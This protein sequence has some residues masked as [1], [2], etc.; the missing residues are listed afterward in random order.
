VRLRIEEIDRHWPM[1]RACAT[2]ASGIQATA[3][4]RA[5]GSKKAPLL[6]PIRTALERYIS[7]EEVAGRTP[8]MDRACEQILEQIP[9]AG[10][11]WVREIYRTMVQQE[12]GRPRK[13][14]RG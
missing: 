14:N 5:A 12:R 10:R 9:E 4:P 7:Q 8:N 2:A 3:V 1:P 13:K 6:Q 11:D